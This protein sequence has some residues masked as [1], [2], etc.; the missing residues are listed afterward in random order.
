MIRRQRA[1]MDPCTFL[2]LWFLEKRHAGLCML[3]YVLPW[4]FPSPTSG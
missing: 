3:P 2:P 1:V 4:S